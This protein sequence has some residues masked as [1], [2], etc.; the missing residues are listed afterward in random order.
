MDVRF[1][2]SDAKRASNL[3]KHGL[4][5]RD[6]AQVFD[7]PAITIEDTRFWYGEKRYM[8]LGLLNDMV[9]SIVHT[10]ND[11]EIRII[12]F[13]SATKREVHLYLDA[14]SH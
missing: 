14:V 13:R 9:V 8:T 10:E 3:A 7:G 5:F 4:D 12:S 1:T 11:E 2:W 6:G